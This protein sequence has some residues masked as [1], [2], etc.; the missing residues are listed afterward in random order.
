MIVDLMR[1]DLGRVSVPGLGA[2]PAD[3]PRR[4]PRG[5]APGLRRRRPR[6]PRR[7]RL[8]PAARDLPAGLGHRRAQGPG[9]GDHRRARADRPRGLHR[10]DRPRQRRCRASSSTSRSARS[11]SPADR[12]WLG[13]GGGIVADST[14]EGEYAECLVKARPLIEAIGGRARPRRRDAEV[15]AAAR[16]RAPSCAS[17]RRR[18]PRIYDTLLVEDGVVLDPDA[19]LARLDASVRAIYG[20]TIRAGLDA[21]VHRRAEGLTGRHRMRIDA[22]PRGSEVDVTMTTPRHRRRCSRLDPRHRARSPA[23][24]A[25]TSGATAGRSARRRARSRPAAARRGR[26]GPR[27]GAGQ[28][29]RGARRRH[30]H[31]AADGRILPGTARARIIE[32]LRDAGVPVFQR[33]L[34]ARR[35]GDS[36]RGLRRQLAARCRARR[37]V[38]RRRRLAGRAYDRV[39]PRRAAA[40]LARRPGR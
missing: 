19:H 10:R 36:D 27:D 33:R 38:R 34:T 7:T 20:T 15:D 28:H 16:R 17:R 39:A 4:A 22:V 23:A 24:S 13:V 5:L 12:V 30:P 1:N 9:D 2:R 37:R 26:L 35:P 6:R 18:Q 29:L 11:S 25:R 31:P 14:P 8:R 3:H 32:I 21:A 40:L